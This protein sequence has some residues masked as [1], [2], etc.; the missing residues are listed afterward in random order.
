MADIE[1]DDIADALIPDLAAL[2][3]PGSHGRTHSG[4]FGNCGAP[5]GM[6][7]PGSARQVQIWIAVEISTGSSSEPP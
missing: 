1:S 2:A 3:S 6:I 5:A 4:S 7:V